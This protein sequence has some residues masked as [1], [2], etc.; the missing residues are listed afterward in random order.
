MSILIWI[1]LGLVA[2]FLARWLMPGRGP[3]GGLLVTI[4][5]GIGGALVGGFLSSVALGIDVTGIN[6]TSIA[7]AVG[8]AVLL[9]IA[10]GYLQKR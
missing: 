6:I 1:V 10:Y 9:I 7:I 5:L 8:G 4:L 2:G 3:G